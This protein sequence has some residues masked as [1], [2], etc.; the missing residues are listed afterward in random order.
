[1]WAIVGMSHLGAISFWSHAEVELKAWMPP[2]IVEAIII[3]III[4]LLLNF[5]EIEYLFLS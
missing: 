2:I 4:I 1:M 3:I 5:V